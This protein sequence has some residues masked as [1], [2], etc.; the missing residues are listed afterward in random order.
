MTG[1]LP[2]ARSIQERLREYANEGFLSCE[3]GLIFLLTEA[4]DEI[5]ALEDE[6]NA[7]AE[8]MDE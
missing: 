8:E 3:R 6:C 2:P 1:E 7:L 5:D 4:A